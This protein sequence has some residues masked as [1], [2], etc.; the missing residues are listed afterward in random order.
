MANSTD[1][2]SVDAPR[3]EPLASGEIPTPDAP[4][5]ATPDAP[6]PDN[7]PGRPWRS[8]GAIVPTPSSR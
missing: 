4:V 1:T 3:D 2:G 8:T 5:A 7:D 6:A